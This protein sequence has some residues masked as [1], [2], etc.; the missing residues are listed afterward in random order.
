[1]SDTEKTSIKKIEHGQPPLD[2][3]EALLQSL[4]YKQDLSRSISA[5]SNFAI[6]FSCCSVLSGLT[7][8]W[9]DAMSDAGSLGVIWGWVITGSFTLIVALSLAEICSAYPTTG[10][11]YFWVSRLATSKWVPLA[12]WVT[13]WCNWIGLCFG[14]TSVDLGLSQFIAGV[15]SVWNPDVNLSVYAQYGIYVGIL[16]VHGVL[17]SVAVSWN[18]AMNQAAFYANMLGIAFIIVV[19]LAITKPLATGEFVFTQFYNGSGFSSN[20]FA[21]L[22]V[23][24]QSQYT[25]SGY[26]SAAH[27]SEETKNS[28]SGS[29]FGILVSVA[30][31][32][33]SGLVFLIAIS[34]MVTD[35]ERQILSENAIQ[36]QMI[37]VFYDGVGGAWTMV[38]LVFVMLSIFFCGSALTLGSSR[39]VYAFARDGAMPFSKHLHSL[40]KKTN[41]PVIAVWFNILVAAIVGVLYMINSTAYEAIVSVNTIGSQM[42]Y[43]VPILLRVTASRTKFKPGPFSL[44]RFSVVT[45]WI[46]SAWLIF[47]CALFITPTTA[48]V[49]PDTM[50]YAV[51]PFAAIMIFSMGYYFIWG[52]KW[53]TGPVRMVDGKEV[54]LDDESI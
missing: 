35:Y 20:G 36:P 10:G 52:R 9:G 54:I 31:N 6:A 25:L 5:F 34:F 32:A 24:L 49:T 26:D 38:F 27:M 2:A 40:N 43:L 13:G 17:N 14:I 30:A 42:S 28:Q 46:A 22:L 47:T 29:P 50:N 7:P 4:G 23:I 33:V 41:S 39:M 1:M 3:D 53:F 51:V 48:P 16:I 21:F 18:G 11:L 45:G 8:M 44:G 15:V 12:C 19:G 37:Q